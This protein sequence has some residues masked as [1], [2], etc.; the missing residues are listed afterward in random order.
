LVWRTGEK[1][2]L[3]L[4]RRKSTNR[5]YPGQWEMPGGKVEPGETGPEATAREFAEEMGVNVLVQPELVGEAAHTHSSLGEIRLRAYECNILAGQD[6]L[7]CLEHDE[8]VWVTPR[9]ALRL[10]LVPA[11]RDLLQALADRK[12]EPMAGLS[13]YGTEP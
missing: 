3:L 1:K 2:A 8:I 6:P 10:D 12:K 5:Y 7:Q 4:G 11:D 9:A 13:S